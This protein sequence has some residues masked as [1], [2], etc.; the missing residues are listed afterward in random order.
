[1]PVPHDPPLAALRAAERMGAALGEDVAEY[2]AILQ[3]GIARMEGELFDGEYFIQKI[4]WKNLRAKNPL[5]VKSMV[6]AYSPE[7]QALM[8]S[9]GPKYQY[10]KGCLSDGVPGSW[11]AL[12]C[13]VG[14][15][16]DAAKVASHV[17]A[18]HRYNFKADLS[19]RANGSRCRSSTRTRS[20]RGSSTRSPRT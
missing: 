18:I 20:G 6:G 10:G 11:L 9:E 15:V 5:E 1:M 8:E 12:V 2:A 4:E 7:A 14:H 3:R 16:L 19:T 17:R 13:G